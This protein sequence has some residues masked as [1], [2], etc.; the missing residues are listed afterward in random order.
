MPVKGCSPV[1]STQVNF[2]PKSLK[3]DLKEY[4]D[5]LGMKAVWNEP[6]ETS[7]LYRNEMDTVLMSPVVN[8]QLL[9][10]RYTAENN[11]LLFC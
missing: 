3:A 10:I 7:R 2:G 1:G 11:D 5:I 9:P 8:L 4:Q 6:K